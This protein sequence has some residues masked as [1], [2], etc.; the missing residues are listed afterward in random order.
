MWFIKKWEVVKAYFVK[1][2]WL[3]KPDPEAYF[4]VTTRW[5]DGNYSVDS[6][7]QYAIEGI[8]TDIAVDTYQLGDWTPRDVFKM[9]LEDNDEKIIISN[10]FT[11][12][13]RGILN[14]LLNIERY[15]RI[16][17]SLYTFEKNGKVSKGATVHNNGE[18]AARKHSRDG[19]SPLVEPIMHKGSVIGNDY[20]A[21]DTFFKNSIKETIKVRIDKSLNE[22]ADFPEDIFDAPSMGWFK[23][24]VI[25][26]NTVVPNMKLTSSDVDTDDLPF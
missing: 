2:K 17:V 14:S 5:E 15:G 23:E 12:V 22:P 24:K 3:Q 20:T 18:K 9:T 4:E 10:S 19:L 13:G 16:K 8:L 6:E 1:I 11:S 21:L 7:K 26:Q 25:T